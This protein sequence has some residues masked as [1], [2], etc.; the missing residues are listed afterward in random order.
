MLQKKFWIPV[1]LV[2]IGVAI[3]GTFWGKHIASQEP[4]KTYKP[5]E[6]QQS[7]APKPPPPGETYE[8]GHWHGDEW[9][10]EPNEVH[11][12]AEVATPEAQGGQ[13]A[14][15]VNAQPP[16]LT[17]E[18]LEI[19]QMTSEEVYEALYEELNKLEKGSEAYKEFADKIKWFEKNRELSDRRIQAAEKLGAALEE[20]ARVSETEEQLKKEMRRIL[21]EME[22]E[23]LE[24]EKLYQEHQKSNPLEQ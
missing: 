16:T 13:I 15:P 2:L 19:M 8:T 22:P 14:Q 20:A 5:V 17:Q 12:P 10:S 18:E 7:T 3:G 4:V 6:F 23:M 9:H 1:L 11:A 21:T 24:A